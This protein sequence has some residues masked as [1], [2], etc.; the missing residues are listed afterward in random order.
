MIQGLSWKEFDTEHLGKQIKS[1][2]ATL[3]SKRLAGIKKARTM[4]WAHAVGVFRKS[5]ID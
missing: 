3:E 1:V 2:K 4:T 5:F